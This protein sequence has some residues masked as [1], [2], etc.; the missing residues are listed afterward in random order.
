MRIFRAITKKRVAVLLLISIF[1]FAGM[2]Q[3]S[4]VRASAALLA[5][6]SIQLSDSIPSDAGVTYTVVFTFPSTTSIKCIDVI[7][8]G[9]AS[10]ITLTTNPATTAPSGM[11]T[12]SAAIGTITGGGLTQGNYTEYNGNN[13][14]LQLEDATGHASTATAAT[15]SFTTITNTS[16]NGAFYA[17]VAT[18][19][20]LASH[21]CS[22]L[23]DNSN[24]MALTTA[25]GVA[26]SATVNPSISFSLVNDASAVNGSAT[27]NTGGGI[28]V[29]STHLT[30]GTVSPATAYVL[31]HTATVSTNGSGGYILYTRYNGAMTNGAQTLADASGTNASP[32]AFNGSGATSAFG[33]T[34]DNSQE[35][36]RFTSN[37]WAKFTT[38]NAEV[39][40]NAGAVNGD[41]THIG[42]ELE[43]SNTQPPGAYTSTVIYTVTPT[44]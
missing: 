35:T 1:T 23:V 3:Y 32:V 24:V 40:K 11:T 4:T 31:A 7:F 2:F 36:G 39:G 8:G 42:Y 10:N 25:S 22:G 13:G 20:T 12:T 16:T 38:T 19:S 37:T 15:L 26:V 33:Y 9:A 30:Y 6:A 41:V 17:Q 34:T 28:T 14:I 27:P 18:Y 44:Y 43:A 29:D 5:S 21:A